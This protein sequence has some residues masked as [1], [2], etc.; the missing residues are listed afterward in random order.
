[1]NTVNVAI[2]SMGAILEADDHGLVV[3]ALKTAMELDVF[4]VIRQGHQSAEDVAQE[5]KCNVHGMSVL[6]DALC[7]K[8]LL[9]KTNGL[10]HL[11]PTSETYLIRSGQGYCTPIF[12][13]WFQAREKFIDFVKTG[14]ATLDLTSPEA[15]DV[16]VSY[17]SPDRVRL[18]EL[19]E[20]VQKR[21]AGSGIQSRMKPGASI[22]DVGSGSGI[23][24][25][26]LLQADSRAHVTAVD[27][28]KVLEIAREIA[29]AMGVAS[30]VT[31]QNGSVE[32]DL[33]KNTFDMVL[34]GS[35]LHYYDIPSAFQILQKMH[36]ALKPGGLIVIYAKAVDEE[37]KSDP[38][39]LSMI[40]VSNCAPHGQHYTFSEYRQML[41]AAGFS[42]VTQSEVAI[43][44]GVK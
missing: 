33:P 5:T 11:T 15:E 30:Q 26:T 39:L 12:L 16:W 34:I 18:P 4:E 32:H 42:D 29:E 19:V 38:A 35:L 36:H 8:D 10:Y 24:S 1:M 6:L 25:F 2:P 27:S 22:L 28:P 31:F 44:S 20:L 43:I 13:A 14:N 40:D 37:R 23:K 3:T 41:E 7:A 17:A 21:W 9:G